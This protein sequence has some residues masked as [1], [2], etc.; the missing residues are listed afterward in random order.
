MSEPRAE[1]GIIGGSGLYEMAGLT[2]VEEIDLS[3]PF[4][5]PSDSLVL[6]TLGNR[7]IAFLPRHG[8]GHRLSPSQVPYRANIFAMKML[9][10]HRILSVSAVGSLK[11]EIRPLDM[12][13]PDQLIDR[14]WSRTSTFFDNG[15]VV[16]L[17]FADPFCSQ[18]MELFY[19]EA[20]R[21]GSRAHLGGTYLAMEGPQ[22]STK[23]ESTLYR[24]WGASVIGMT[25]LPEAKHAREAEVCY[26]VLACST[27]Y[28]CWHPDHESV[29]AE[30]IIANLLKNTERAKAI[31]K[32]VVLNMPV[33]KTCGCGSAMKNAI[34]TAPE[35]IPAQVK[36]SLAPLL[37]K[38]IRQ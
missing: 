7:R 18:L 37:G 14:T 2:N 36:E 20:R 21:E 30:M 6:G 32:N 11:E 19:Q 38:Y 24:S 28:D 31:V 34:V 12:V 8:R 1:I 16:H 4:G 35:K 13:V 17:A 27:D 23:A 5:T 33:D 25:A 29:S 9:G 22:F 26:A 15:I 3:T 10:V